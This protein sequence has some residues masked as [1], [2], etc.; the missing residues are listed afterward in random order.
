MDV[1]KTNA[2][3]K[4]TEIHQIPNPIPNPILIK[5]V[6]SIMYVSQNFEIYIYRVFHSALQHLLSSQKRLRRPIL[7]LHIDKR[8]PIPN[9]SKKK[10]AYKFVCKFHCLIIYIHEITLN[11]LR[12]FFDFYIENIMKFKLKILISYR[13]YCFKQLTY[14]TNFCIFKI[15]N[16]RKLNASHPLFMYPKILKFTY[17]MYFILLYNIY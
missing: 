2:D 7:T 15:D 4:R 8:L 13:S 12:F 6:A 1:R 17:I 9:L 14:Q 11:N 3:Y 16:F 5:C 10:I